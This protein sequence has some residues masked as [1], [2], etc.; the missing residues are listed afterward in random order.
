MLQ[1]IFNYSAVVGIYTVAILLIRTQSFR[2]LPYDRSIAFSE[3]N[4][5][6]SAI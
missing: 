3:A 1:I 5:T 4:S 2:N 6:Q